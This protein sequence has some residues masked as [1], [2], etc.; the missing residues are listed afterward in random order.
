MDG[1]AF[2][3]G[4]EGTAPAGNVD[5]LPTVLAVLGIDIDH[6]IDGRVLGEALI[7]G[8]APKGAP[9]EIVLTSGNKAGR[10]THLSVREYGGTRYLNRAWAE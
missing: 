9:R 10:R 2:R 1:S 8:D 5:I 6:R 3:N 4:V 7:G